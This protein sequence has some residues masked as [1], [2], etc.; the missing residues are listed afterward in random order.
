[1]VL[2]IGSLLFLLPLIWAL[3]AS[4]K[5][6][7]EVFVYP[8]E[9]IPNP[10]VSPIWQNYYEALTLI[11]LLSFIYN[12]LIINILCIA[13][14]LISSSLCS[15]GFARLKFPGRDVLFILVLTMMMMPWSAIFVPQYLLYSKLGWVDTWLPLFVPT[16][17]AAG[18]GSAFFIFLMRQFFLSIPREIDNAS[19]IDGA[20]TFDIYW[21][22]I[23]PMSKPVLGIVTIF[24]FMWT[25]N[26]FILPLIYLRTMSKFTIALGLSFFRGM[27]QTHWHYLMSATM[28]AAI[29][30]IILFL[31]AQKY[32]IQGVVITGIKE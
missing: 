7:R 18:G 2:A 32:F 29:P 5:P 20:N 21:R 11:P 6:L 16:F 13:G 15:F 14:F 27:Y 30:C 25:W 19:R 17:F 4:L 28:I 23:L 31:V 26:D 3:S 9:I 22:I 12:S 10:P 1:M 24:S 8:P